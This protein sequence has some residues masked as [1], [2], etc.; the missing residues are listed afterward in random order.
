MEESKDV[1]KLYYITIAT[2]PHKV[3][4]KIK[5]IVLKN[6]ETIIVLGT[7]ENRVIGWEA[8]VNF[9]VKLR[10]VAD[11]LKRPKLNDQDI[12]LFT[13]A[14]DV[15][16]C[17]TQKEI[18]RRYKTFQTP[19]VFGCEKGCHPDPSRLSQYNTLHHEFPYLNSGL[20]IGRVK[21]LRE[22]MTNYEYN[23]ADDD[24]R[25]WTTQY[26]NNPDKIT[27]DHENYIFLNTVDMDMDSFTY[28]SKTNVA[29]YKWRNP[30]F[31]HVNGPV[32]KMIEDFL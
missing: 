5:S 25:F 12:I 19:I 14:Y 21:E 8:K 2:K 13:D 27:L 15:A 16:Y 23:D 32:K 20:F 3:L 18:L 24:Q 7:Q 22:C 31:V 9:G 1:V 29:Y 11:F 10:E 30:Q 6:G 26:L 4:D 17:G 28:D